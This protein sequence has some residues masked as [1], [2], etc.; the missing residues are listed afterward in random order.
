MRLFIFSF[1][2]A[3]IGSVFPY[4]CLNSVLYRELV[5]TFKNTIWIKPKYNLIV[6]FY[7][8]D[9]QIKVLMTHSEECP[10]DTQRNF[11]QRGSAPRSNPSYPFFKTMT[12]DRQGTP[13]RI[14]TDKWYPFHKPSSER[15]ASLLTAVN[16]SSF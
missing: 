4:R 14:P 10:G 11:I 3:D 1:N 7:L 6:Q 13:F 16:A 8:E 12:F 2:L 9:A 5:E 15:N